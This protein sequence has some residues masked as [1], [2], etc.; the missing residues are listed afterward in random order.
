MT[1]SLLAPG[2][3]HRTACPT[4]TWCSDRI[5][6][7]IYCS[8]D[9]GCGGATALNS[10]TLHTTARL[11]RDCFVLIFFSRNCSSRSPSLST[12]TVI[13]HH[14]QSTSNTSSAPAARLDDMRWRQCRVGRCRRRVK[15]LT[16]CALDFRVTA[17]LAC[18][19]FSL[20][21]PDSESVQQKSWNFIPFT[22]HRGLSASAY[23][24]LSSVQL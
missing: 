20:R 6:C 21:S 7:G 17:A 12:A 22:V 8:L 15:W 1:D 10:C 3:A 24:C 2:H 18:I 23:P 4:N 13:R 9:T 14:S 5:I 19:G 16:D 11:P